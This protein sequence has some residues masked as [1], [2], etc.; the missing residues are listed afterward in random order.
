M[1][2]LAYV[3][4]KYQLQNIYVGTDVIKSVKRAHPDINW[5][6]HIHQTDKAQGFDEL[7]FEPEITKPLIEGGKSD[8][9]KALDAMTSFLQ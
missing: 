2:A 6:H 5:R 7:S 4:R 9:K 1:N 3:A 8:A